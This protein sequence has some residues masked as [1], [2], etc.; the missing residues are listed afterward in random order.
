MMPA[1]LMFGTVPMIANSLPQ[2]FDLG[3]Q[4]LVSHFRDVVVH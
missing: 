4:L 3:D 2:L 1:E